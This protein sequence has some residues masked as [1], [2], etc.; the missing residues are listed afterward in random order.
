M[1]GVCVSPLETYKFSYSKI[2]TITKIHLG[3]VLLYVTTVV[4]L[5]TLLF[6]SFFPFFLLNENVSKIICSSGTFYVCMTFKFLT[7]EGGR[8]NAPL[9][10]HS[11]VPL[12]L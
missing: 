4:T 11:T 5:D 2:E 6:W 12:S 10:S 1:A 3:R 9:T 7:T 8:D